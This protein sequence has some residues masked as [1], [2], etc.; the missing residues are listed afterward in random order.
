MK[1][2]VLK[3]DGTYHRVNRRGNAPLNAQEY[4]CQ[5]ATRQAQKPDA[6][7]D[8]RVFIPAEPQNEE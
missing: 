2:R 7:K 4:F 1:A 5:E 8:N 3:E 6:L